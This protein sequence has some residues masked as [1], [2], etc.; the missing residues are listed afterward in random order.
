MSNQ[1][2][3]HKAAMLGQTFRIQ[4]LIS[5]GQKVEVYD[6]KGFTPM[7]HAANAGHADCVEMLI[8]HKANVHCKDK[9]SSTPLHMACTNLNLDMVKALLNAGAD[10]N[11][12][13]KN[14]TPLHNLCEARDFEGVDALDRTKKDHNGAH[15]VAE[16]LLTHGAQPNAKNRSGRTALHQAVQKGNVD[17]ARVLMKYG[18]NKTQRDGLGM[19]PFDFAEGNK[20]MKAILDGSPMPSPVLEKPSNTQSHTSHTQTQTHTQSHAP[21]HY[22]APQATS[23]TSSNT[24]KFCTSCGDKVEK[25]AKFCGNCGTRF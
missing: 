2:E 14:G 17:L 13:D 25:A 5:E 21:A 7:H 1:T 10:P 11:A 24:P 16:Y 12:L 19:T 9:D 23:S 22:N 4:T 8:K 20:E 18:A 6:S 15:E 3:L